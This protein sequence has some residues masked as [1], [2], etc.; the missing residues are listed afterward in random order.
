MGPWP[1]SSMLR[2]IVGKTSKISRPSGPNAE[3][4]SSQTIILG[5][6]ASSRAM[7]TRCSSVR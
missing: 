1:G 4:G 6:I 5:F 3:V 2:M 7:A